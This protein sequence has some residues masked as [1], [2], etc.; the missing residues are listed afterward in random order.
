[1]FAKS[2]A[3]AILAFGSVVVSLNAQP[4]PITRTVLQTAD[5]PGD[6]YASKLVM[7]DIAPGA[8]VPS[9]THPGMEFAYVIDGDG[10]LSVEGQPDKHLKTGDSSQVP[11]MAPHSF[12]NLRSD[13]PVKLVVTYIVEKD[14]PLATM[15]QK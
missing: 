4:S 5:F 1:M 2:I 6:K 11:A 3:L 15:L 13:K 10:T 9:H 12:T 14:K 8:K 7:V